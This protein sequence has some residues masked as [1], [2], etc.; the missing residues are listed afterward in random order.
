MLKL[1]VCHDVNYGIGYQGTLPWG[2]FKEDMN[3]FR[4]TTTEVETPGKMNAVIMGR[5]TWES[6]PGKFR[7]LKNRL[8][9]IVS[10]TMDPGDTG[11]STESHYVRKNYQEALECAMNNPRVEK[12]FVI[13]GER[14]YREA[15]E[16]GVDCIYSTTI[17]KEYTCDRHIDL[18]KYL[19]DYQKISTTQFSSEDAH[20]SVFRKK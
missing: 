2:S 12:V 8:N 16:R 3:F 5:N 18:P 10:S 14:L 13:G 7:P 6:I 9:V 20:V 4:K 17:N 11:D 15:L 19:D 1:I